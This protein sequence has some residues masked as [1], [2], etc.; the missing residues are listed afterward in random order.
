MCS[1]STVSLNFIRYPGTIQVPAGMLALFQKT[2][3]NSVFICKYIYIQANYAEFWAD[4]N[5]V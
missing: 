5:T 2:Y 1:I 4:Q 3:S